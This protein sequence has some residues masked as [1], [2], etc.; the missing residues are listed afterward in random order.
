MTMPQ[1]LSDL[2]T[3]M[4]QHP[5]PLMRLPTELRLEI[6][7]YLLPSQFHIRFLQGK[8]YVTTCL[9]PDPDDPDDFFTPAMPHR[10][11]RWNEMDPVWARRCAS[12]WGP[13]WKCDEEALGMRSEDLSDGHEAHVDMAGLLRA[14]RVM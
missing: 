10:Y 3:S 13:H 9:Q 4:P 14:C 1:S 7:S 6:Y 5:S 11:A 2:T 12:T 8:L